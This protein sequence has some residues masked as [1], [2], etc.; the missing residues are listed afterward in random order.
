MALRIPR[1]KAAQLPKE[2]TGAERVDPPAGLSDFDGA[3][4][5]KEELPAALPVSDQ[6]LA[7]VNLDVLRQARH[8]PGAVPWCIS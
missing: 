4:E 6:D 3:S 8:P 2:V 5:D 7:L 1:L